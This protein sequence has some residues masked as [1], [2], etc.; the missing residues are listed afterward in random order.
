MTE[1][2]HRK[3]HVKNPVDYML[4]FISYIIIWSILFVYCFIRKIKEFYKLQIYFKLLF[5]R[6]IVQGIFNKCTITH[7]KKL[8]KNIFLSFLAFLKNENN[9]TILLSK[10]ISKVPKHIY[11]V[12]KMSD[13]IILHKK[14]LMN[15]IL[16]ILIY[17]YE[18]KVQYVTIYVA[19]HF[20]NSLFYDNLTQGLCGHN[21]YMNRVIQSTRQV[22]RNITNRGTC[23]CRG[24]NSS[25]C[26]T[27]NDAN[28]D[29][30]SN[31]CTTSNCANCGCTSN[32]CSTSNCANCS[33]TSNRCF[34]SNCANCSC[35]S[36][37]CFTSNCA[38]CSCTSN[39]C[40][41]SNCANCSCTSNRCSTSNCNC[42]QCDAHG[43]PDEFIITKMSCPVNNFSSQKGRRKFS[44]MY[45]TYENFSLHLKFM[46][47]YFSHD[48]LINIAEHS[49]ITSEGEL[50]A[51]NFL[52]STN[53]SIENV[54]RK[55]FDLDKKEFYDK[56]ENFLKQIWYVFYYFPK[57]VMGAFFCKFKY[58]YCLF[59]QKI[60]SL[61]SKIFEFVKMDFSFFRRLIAQ[62]FSQN[63]WKKILHGQTKWSNG[64]MDTS[65]HLTENGSI[66]IRKEERQP[67][68]K[69][70]PSQ[71][72][73][74]YLSSSLNISSIQKNR[75]L[76]YNTHDELFESCL[77]Q[78]D[79]K[80]VEIIKNFINNNI[81][82][83]VKP[84]YID[85]FR[86]NFNALYNYIP[87]DVVISLRMG[88]ID[89]L[90]S[91]LICYKTKKN[92]PKK[93]CIKFLFE[94][95]SSFVFLYNI[96]HPFEQNGIQPWVLS[97][98]EIYE[99]FSYNINSV[100]KAIMY[101]SSSMQRYGR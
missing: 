73:S 88:L 77:L 26:T 68:D 55:M 32:R 94:Y 92:V 44:K 65:K 5:L 3:E 1:G 30:T 21:F 61:F 98:A 29:R 50:I 75:T 43:A 51:E 47:K 13:I 6:N 54:L 84:I 17:L 91:T 31:S 33:C 46:N 24:F 25:N 48:K 62:K 60:A 52:P 76:N 93:N 42:P 41:T 79:D 35:T 95:F 101:Y 12:L 70:P 16:N 72:K 53:K 4:L 83:Y 82:L 97:D 20:F 11:I 38:N 40:S 14:K 89:Y 18:L 58:F 90:L 34:T 57:E 85:V 19:D 39:R 22:S 87:V 9:S 10:H 8:Y 74:T 80:S 78:N 96:I 64:M 99:F 45:C 69:R 49:N 15:Y 37:R 36:N 23:T 27:A 7:V 2:R 86:N 67:A 100:K 71:A 81:P 63:K 59:K 56:N 66:D 28:S